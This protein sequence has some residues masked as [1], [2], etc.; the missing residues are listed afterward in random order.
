MRK[1][2]YVCAVVGVVLSPVWCF[3]SPTAFLSKPKAP[4]SRASIM[5]MQLQ[6]LIFDCDGVLCDTERDGHRLSFNKAFEEWGIKAEWDEG[7]R[8]VHA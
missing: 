8:C 1:A 2:L 6:A 5:R 3:V 7:M 4:Q